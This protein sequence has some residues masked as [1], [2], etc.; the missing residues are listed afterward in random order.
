MW[1]RVQYTECGLA[2]EGGLA[3]M[4]EGQGYGGLAHDKE[5]AD[6]A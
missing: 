3:H 5:G 6:Q 2:A 4:E 1:A